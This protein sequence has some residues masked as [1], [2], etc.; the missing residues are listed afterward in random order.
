[1]HVC[2]VSQ[3]VDVLSDCASQDSRERQLSF[4]RIADQLAPDTCISTLVLTAGESTSTLEFGN[5]RFLPQEAYRLR[6]MGRVLRALLELHR[7]QPI[8]VVATQNIHGLHWAAL[9]F[10]SM[11]R[12]PVLGQIHSDIASPKA[13]ETAYRGPY[14]QIYEY[15]V[16][17]GL[18]RFDALRV[19]NNACKRYVQ[20]LGYPRSIRVIPVSS[21]IPAGNYAGITRGQQVGPVGTVLFVGRLVEVKNIFRWLEAA[22]LIAAELPD[23]RFIL[24]GGGPQEAALKEFAAARGIDDRV[25]FTGPQAPESL[26]RFYRDAEVLLLTSDHEGF[27]RVI[28][29]AMRHG[30]VPVSVISNGPQDIIEQ[31]EDGFLVEADPRQAA[32][33]VVYLL[34]NR[35]EL[36]RMRQAAI[37]K[38]E[39]LYNPDVLAR[40][41]V[42]FL[43]D[44]AGNDRAPL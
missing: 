37:S 5:V 1:M 15:L 24:V 18:M 25:D 35:Q 44:V 42:E 12:V 2:Q 14:G 39:R 41:W 3:D 21:R 8:D 22:A 32:A 38:A 4:G 33:R 9:V 27:G 30:T 26:P 19:V 28:V 34:K 31:G 16:L 7:R 29:E 10:G 40:Q 6:H 23:T 11:K 36:A 20:G 13:S 17:R 43:M